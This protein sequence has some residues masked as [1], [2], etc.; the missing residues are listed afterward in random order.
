[1]KLEAITVPCDAFWL[2]TFRP[3]EA[4]V[5]AFEKICLRGSMFTLL[6][7]IML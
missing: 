5:V 7:S 3:Y 4:T 2:A 6:L 1:M